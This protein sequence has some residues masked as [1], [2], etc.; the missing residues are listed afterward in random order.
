VLL[1]ET[2]TTK[3]Y[4]SIK[5]IKERF[6]KM[7]ANNVSLLLSLREKELIKQTHD[8]GQ[9]HSISPFNHQIRPD[10]KT[11][12]HDLSSNTSRTD[13]ATSTPSPS[14]LP[15]NRILIVDDDLDITT[16][17]KMSLERFGFAVDVFNNPLLALSNYKAGIYGLLLLDIRMPGMNG[18]E[19]CQRIKDVDNNVKVCF[20]TAYDEE[21][22]KDLGILFPKLEVDCFI[23]K[24]IELQKLTG[25]IKSKLG[26]N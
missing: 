16:L 19:L 13:T 11:D 26:Y 24:P 21:Y 17:F 25:I 12:L 5:R 1:Q 23:R 7:K 6:R 10:A 20:V 18:L 4:N 14:T 3:Y 15:H 9:G 22:Q 2:I 8:V